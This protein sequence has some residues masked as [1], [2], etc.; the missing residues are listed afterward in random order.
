MADIPTLDEIKSGASQ[1]TSPLAK[2]L[3]ILFEASPVITTTLEPQ[4]ALLIQSHPP[5]SFSELIDIS[6]QSLSIWNMSEQA[7]F[8]AGHPRIGEVKNLSNLSAKEQGQGT[9]PGVTPTPPEILARLKHLNECYEAKYPGLRYITFVNG[10]TRGGIAQEMEDKLRLDHNL[11]PNE[12]AVSSLVPVEVDGEEWCAELK[13][14]IK[15]IGYI[16]KSR[17]GALGVQ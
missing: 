11:S 15:D 4:V 17:L 16:A 8:I 13:R 3:E 10:R 14:A 6:L 12:P 9:S 1:P 7:A 5:A 2:A